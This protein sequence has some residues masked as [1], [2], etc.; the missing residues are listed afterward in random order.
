MIFLTA[1]DGF[2]CF[3]QTHQTSICFGSDGQN[4][5]DFTGKVFKY[6]TVYSQRCLKIFFGVIMNTSLMH[7]VYEYLYHTRIKKKKCP[8]NK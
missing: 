5:T 8:L 2:V 1:I 7:R 4:D 3:E 6:Y